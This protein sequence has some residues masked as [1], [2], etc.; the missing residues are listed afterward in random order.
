MYLLPLR[1]PVTVAR[2]IATLCQLV[3]GRLTFGVGIGGEDRHEIEVC[4]VDPRTRGRRCDESLALLRQL[5]TGR[6]VDHRGEFYEVEACRALPA[7][8]PPVPCW[9]AAAGAGRGKVAWRHK[10]QLW[11]GFG[12]DRPEARGHVSRAMEGFYRIPFEQFERYTP[13]GRPE[14]VAEALDPYLEVGLRDFDLTPCAGSAS[15]GIAASA[16]VKRLLAARVG[17]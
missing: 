9:S 16:E 11:V 2:S 3:P 10:L 14:Q 15:A 7:P 13:Y 8:E 17:R 1:H 12:D 6:S 5:L 4:G